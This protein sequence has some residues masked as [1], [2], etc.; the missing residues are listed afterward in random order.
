MNLEDAA[1]VV[2]VVDVEHAARRL[3][4]GLG[5]R[6]FQ[7]GQRKRALVVRGTLSVPLDDLQNHLRGPSD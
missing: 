3:G 6:E 7:S 5:N 2:V 4:I 1:A